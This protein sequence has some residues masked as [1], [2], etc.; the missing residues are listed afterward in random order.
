[1]RGVCRVVIGILCLGQM[2]IPA[3]AGMTEAAGMT[4]VSGIT[5]HAGMTKP[6]GVTSLSDYLAAVRAQ[7]QGIRSAE[8]S[9]A[10]AALQAKQAELLTGHS[11]YANTQGT[12]DSKLS[13]LSSFQGTHT[14]SATATVGTAWTGNTGL[15]SN[16]SY[17]YTYT[18]LQGSSL[19][20]DPTYHQSQLTLDITQPLW[21]N[22]NGSELKAN[23]ELIST[24]A[25][26]KQYADRYQI[27]RILATAEMTYWRVAMARQTVDLQ[28]KSLDRAHKLLRWATERTRANLADSSDALQ[29]KAALKF[30]QLQV[31]TARAELDAAQR[32]YNANLGIDSGA[33]PTDLAPLPS[34]AALQAPQ[35]NGTRD[36]LE[37]AKAQLRIAELNDKLQTQAL[38]PSLDLVGLIA[39]NSFNNNA[40]TAFSDSLSLNHPTATIGVQF[41]TSLDRDV[42][43]SIRKGI[44]KELE[45]RQLA[46]ERKEFEVRQEWSELN[47]Q[48]AAAKIRF[49]IASELEQAQKAKWIYET[50]Q[51]RLG[52]ST[53]YQVVAFEQDYA[54]GQ[55]ARL[56]AQAHLLNVL[57]TL[58]TFGR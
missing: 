58:K 55:A 51:H 4:E 38:T 50:N 37:A 11:L 20:T 7:H 14:D 44:H 3:F 22:G 41:S 28:Q 6:T 5:G 1:M 47:Q 43:H 45:A 42:I 34:I 49:E 8:E 2:W 30:R 27:K 24:Q 40:G 35:W 16:L 13:A 53:M 39:L 9:Q 48:F 19:I 46:Y 29:A 56:Q 57:T 25:T 21:R 52:R 32:A 15:K 18:N 54:D 36:D 26:A 12:S 10:A 33:V 31:E 23:K 17:T